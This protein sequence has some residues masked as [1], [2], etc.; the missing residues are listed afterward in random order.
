MTSE[1]ADDEPRCATCGKPLTGRDRYE[2]KCGPCREAEALSTPASGRPR[3]VVCVS[4]GATNLPGERRC[5]HCGAALFPSSSPRWPLAVGML[6]VLG[7][8]FGVVVMVWRRQRSPRPARP[9]VSRAAPSRP[10]W[11]SEPVA[12]KPEPAAVTTPAPTHGPLTRADE[13]CVR[14]ETRELLALVARGDYDRAIDNYLQSDE[15]EFARAAQALAAITTGDAQPGFLRWSARMINEGRSRVAAALRRLGDAQPRWSVAFL[16][17]LA[18]KPEVSS[19]HL[20]LEDRT[21]AA[22]KWHLES[23]FGGLE[24]ASARV[25][26][27]ERTPSGRYLVVVDWEGQR[28][29]RWLHDEPTDLVWEKQAVGWVLK[30]SLAARLERLRETLRSAETAKGRPEG[31]EPR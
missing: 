18:R 8:L 16:A 26:E 1:T 24:P 10:A 25:R 9:A 14:E 20:P 7:V 28:A 2:G 12:A 29:A 30:V 27:V 11:L 22:L 23:L 6:L 3:M 13:A 5:S 31:A 21:R 17:L 15:K 19:P 4:C